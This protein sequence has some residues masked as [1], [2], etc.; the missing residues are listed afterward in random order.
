MDVN[1]FKKVQ[2]KLVVE[3]VAYACTLCVHRLYLYLIFMLFVLFTCLPW[4]M[5]RFYKFY[6]LWQYALEYMCDDSVNVHGAFLFLDYV[7][8]ST[9]TWLSKKVV[10]LSLSLSY[11]HFSIYL[12]RISC[13]VILKTLTKILHA[14]HCINTHKEL[15]S[16]IRYV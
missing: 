14:L 3:W 7:H 11:S 1:Q 4:K 2:D 13:S 15:M 6:S 5:Q 8:H 10:E 12:I 9:H 16:L